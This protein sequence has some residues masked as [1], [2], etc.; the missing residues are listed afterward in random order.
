MLG[1]G[2]NAARQ[3]ANYPEIRHSQLSCLCFRDLIS[4]AELKNIDLLL[5]NINQNHPYPFYFTKILLVV[6]DFNIALKKAV[7]PI[8]R[9]ALISGN[10]ALKGK[11]NSE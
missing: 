2:I 3:R 1:P 10:I 7:L 8:F 5:Q 6:Q 9:D 11:S 4:N